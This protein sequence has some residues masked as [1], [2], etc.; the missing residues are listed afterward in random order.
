MSMNPSISERSVVVI[1][2]DRREMSDVQ[3]VSAAMT[4]D[5]SA[6]V[7]LCDRHSKKILQRIYRITN[8]W[9][10]A[11]DALQDTL[12][13]AFV[14]LKDFEGR[15]SFSSWLT[16]IA[17]NSA[18]MGLRKKRRFPISIDGTY[19]DSQDWEPWEPQ[20]HKGTPESLYAQRERE[21]LLRSAILRLPSTFREVVELRHGRECSTLE[22]A[23]AL[24][25]SVAAAK[26]RLSRARMAVRA[27]FGVKAPISP[28]TYDESRQ[29]A[30]MA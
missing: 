4:G 14:H 22:I 8:N 15:S 7:E 3:L 30:R 23:K 18:L 9:E 13:R 10:D 11:E 5:S 1:N 2:G 16:R 25:I 21:E 19:D 29:N 26:S 12:L 28:R 6:F 27:C 24:G 20:D 17:I